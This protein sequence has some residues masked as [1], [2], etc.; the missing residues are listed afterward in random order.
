MARTKQVPQQKEN[1]SSR[2]STLFLFT[3]IPMPVVS[4]ILEQEGKPSRRERKLPADVLVM[5]IIFMAIYPDYNTRGVF[6][7]MYS[8]IFPGLIPDKCANVGEVA[9]SQARQRLGDKVMESL[10]LAAGAG[11]LGRIFIKYHRCRSLHGSD[12][13][14]KICTIISGIR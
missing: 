4:A 8:D 2:I 13:C 6:E 3:A 14:P 10:L 9:I 7:A 5:L 11:Q 12:N 1:I